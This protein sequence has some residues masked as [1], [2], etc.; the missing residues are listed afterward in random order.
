MNF[1]YLILKVLFSS[2]FN[3]TFETS[4]AVLSSYDWFCQF[5]SNPVQ[6]SPYLLFD[7]RSLLRLFFKFCSFFWPKI[8]TWS[9]TAPISYQ[10]LFA[11]LSK[12]YLEELFSVYHGI[13]IAM[14]P[15]YPDSLPSCMVKLQRDLNL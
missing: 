3:L 4:F 14:L 2:F 1:L 10:L 6:F 7:L 12:T 11:I 5:F 9:L 8:Q 13:D 15:E